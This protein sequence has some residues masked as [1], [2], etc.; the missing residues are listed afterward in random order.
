MTEAASRTTKEWPDHMRA[1]IFVTAGVVLL[2]APLGFL[3]SAIS[4]KLDLA[5]VQQGSETAFK[6]EFSADLRYLVLAVVVGSAIGWFGGVLCARLRGHAYLAGILI[7]V[8]VGGLICAIVEA[9]VGEV[10]Q[11]KQL[12]KVIRPGLDPTTIDLISFRLRVIEAVAVLP[13]LALA[14]FSLR[15]HVDKWRG[16]RQTAKDSL[17]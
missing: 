2:G 14:T 12:N 4:P 9:R 17:G 10:Y 13:V 1:A 8:V 6:A 11:M 7:G 3:W 15:L 16:S 5:Q